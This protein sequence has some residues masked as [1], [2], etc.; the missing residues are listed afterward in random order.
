MLTPPSTYCFCLFSYLTTI[1]TAIIRFPS[2][3][4]WK[5]LIRFVYKIKIISAKSQMYSKYAC[6]VI[7]D[8]L[9]VCRY[10]CVFNLERNVNNATRK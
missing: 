2:T 3:Q 9:N 7:G 6:Q 5:F 8:L 1:S 4:K 10:Y